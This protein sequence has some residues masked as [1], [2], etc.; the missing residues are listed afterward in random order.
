MS[1]GN[2]DLSLRLVS[3]PCTTV[4]VSF[5]VLLPTHNKVKLFFKEGCMHKGMTL[6]V[7]SLPQIFCILR[8]LNSGIIEG[9]RSMTSDRDTENLPKH[10]PFQ[11]DWFI[12]CAKDLK[13]LK[14]ILFCHWNLK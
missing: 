10:F 2:S 3:S 9:R 4:A 12:V 1:N 13:S 6:I 14:D 11:P 5:F 8:L 7:N